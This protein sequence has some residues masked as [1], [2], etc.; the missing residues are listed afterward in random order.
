MFKFFQ[1]SSLE[2]S[3]GEIFRWIPSENVSAKEIDRRILLFSN[4][5]PK[6]IQHNQTIEEM[7]GE[8]SGISPLCS[9]VDL[10]PKIEAKDR[11]T[12]IFFRAT[13]SLNTSSPLYTFLKEKKQFSGSL[14]PIKANL[15]A[16]E[17]RFFY[18]ESQP[19]VTIL[20]KAL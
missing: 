13:G 9:C 1:E 10:T 20:L 7:I 12:I 6:I 3:N 14:L 2:L 16:R 5:V 17:M 8:M 4:N 11:A 18:I 15:L 19:Y